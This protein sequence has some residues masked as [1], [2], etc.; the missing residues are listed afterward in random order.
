VDNLYRLAQ[1][2][3]DNYPYCDQAYYLSQLLQSG[4]TVAEGFIVP[5]DVL[6][7]YLEVLG[8]SEI[9]LADLRDS[10]LHLNIHE[11]QQLRNIAQKLRQRILQGDP[12]AEWLDTL[13]SYLG[14]INNPFV[15]LKPFFQHEEFP[16]PNTMLETVVCLNQAEAVLAGLQ[17]VWG[18]LFRARHLFCWR[19][20]GLKLS[21]VNLAV[22]VQPVGNAIA[23]GVITA[24]RE[25]LEI[26][27][28][29]GLPLAIH[30]GEVLPD[31]YIVN[32]QTGGLLKQHLGN[33]T[34]A[35]YLNSSPTA[36]SPITSCLLTSEEQQS[37]SLI[38]EDLAILTEV[39]QQLQL[40]MPLWGA[41]TNAP[42]FILAWQ[43]VKPENDFV[44]N[45]VVNLKSNDLES[46]RSQHLLITAFIPQLSQVAVRNTLLPLKGLAVASGEI[47][48]TAQV[49]INPRFP[50]SASPGD[51]NPALGLETSLL[52]KILVAEIVLPEWLP[53]LQEA[54]GIITEQGGMTS[55]GAIIA[56][57]LGIPAVVGV[58]GA[59]RL[60]QPGEMVILDGNQG[61]IYR[62]WDPTLTQYGET[63]PRRSLSQ[64][65]LEDSPGE[66]LPLAPLVQTPVS[67]VLQDLVPE[68]IKNVSLSNSSQSLE[69]P[70]LFLVKELQRKLALQET[71]TQEVGQNFTSRLPRV[72]ELLV[73]LS[74]PKG[75]GAAARLPVDGV[76]LL[77]SEFILTEILQHHN[78]STFQDI[79]MLGMLGEQVSKP[80]I[81]PIIPTANIQIAKPLGGEAI[82]EVPLA[83]RV[84]TALADK[85]TEFAERFAPRPV[86]YRSADWRSDE[87]PSLFRQ[88]PPET[89][90]VLG[91][92]G[93]Y[94]YTKN[95]Q[96]FDWELAALRE[97]QQRGYDNLRL[98]L[99]FV[100]TVEEFEFC[101]QRVEQEGLYQSAQFQLWIMAEVPSVVFLLADYVRAGVQGIS[102]GSNDLTQ[103][104]LGRD[105]NQSEMAGV[106]RESHPAVLAAM[107]QLITTARQLKIPCSICGQAPVNFPEL[108]EQLVAWGITSIS[109]EAGS[110]EM[111]DRAIAKAEY[112]LLLEL[113]HNTPK[114]N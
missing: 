46:N 106:L 61:M 59:T 30:R 25:Q 109:V 62:Y 43:I 92:R 114:D 53:F 45:S 32:P 77:R 44:V 75:I 64:D 85:I 23:S 31:R 33:K 99:P 66:T 24:S 83:S 68:N 3:I 73:N 98:L 76:G 96:L 29:W 57:E 55:H 11:P 81:P 94:L 80:I 36:S 65:S 97:V 7:Q 103:L 86:F 8:A 79:A 41:N 12:P 70:G 104:I 95:P 40:A 49:I 48:A 78:L 19:Q 84:I 110:V 111:V 52:G 102:I 51:R 105:R 112:K 67:Q 93:T 14:E 54:A 5:G 87:F 82:T 108:I 34:R 89:N 47:T 72:T 88:E 4:Y 58:K 91:C 22:L 39:C 15:E 71:S 90:P 18:Q 21:Q 60:I 16:A 26:E 63:A 6:W 9:L 1:I 42:H 100:R 113:V 10:D 38:P 101:R 69:A 74:Q 35:Y 20:G 13:T 107:K 2:S 17:E 37:Y 56:R 50:L 28:T 27:A